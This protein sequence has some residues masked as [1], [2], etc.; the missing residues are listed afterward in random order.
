M[1][2][3]EK[4]RMYFRAKAGTTWIRSNE[5]RRV[6]SALIDLAA[7]RGMAVHRWSIAS[8]FTAA[9]GTPE[10][11]S[12]L[13]PGGALAS[14]L[15]TGGQWKS[16]KH[17]FILHDF[18]PFVASNNPANVP[19]I[20]MAREV[21]AALRGLP[22]DLERMVVFM[23]PDVELP[24]ELRTEVPIITWELPDRNTM[25]E[26]VKSV[27]SVRSLKVTNEE[28]EQYGG[29]LLGLTYDEAQNALARS[30][31][32]MGGFEQ[33]LLFEE[34]KAIIERDG[35]LE[36]TEPEPMG[37]DAIGGLDL[38]KP[39]AIE[40]Y[41]AFSPEAQEYGLPYPKGVLLSGIAG[42]G[43]S[44]S[45]K[46]IATAWKMVLLRLDVGKLMGK[47][48]GDSEAGMR[49]MLQLVDTLAPCILFVDEIEKGLSG[50]ES[51]GSVDGG[52]TSRMFGSLLTWMQERKS[53]APVIAT[54]NDVGKLPPEL[55]R[56]GRFDELFFVDLPKLTD[57]LDIFNIHLK[58]GKRGVELTLENA[59]GLLRITDGFSGADIAQTVIDAMHR[60]FGDNVREVTVTDLELAANNTVP[61]SRSRPE[62]I[63]ALR[64]WA[65]EGG[66]RLAASREA[67]ATNNDRFK[68]L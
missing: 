33:K 31:V 65:N 49:R 7:E 64:A 67:T 16:G 20:R 30:L 40:R 23:S 22:R 36:W 46:C 44:L 27:A 1:S 38:L 8:G 42:T 60:A 43:K 15:P 3:V 2:S 4:T 5:E 19:V 10:N 24:S 55:L 26:L 52:T 47:Y 11:A 18:S 34:K 9:D 28:A 56:K 50:T 68:D 17:L 61:L 51:S 39:W 63:E 13:D 32:T 37:L 29:A 35:L 45:A 25:T 41:G 54:A 53:P 6:V 66:A 62:K 48:V 59:A 58:K 12:M 57:R 21:G 14:T